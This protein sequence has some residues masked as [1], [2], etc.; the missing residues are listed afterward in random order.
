[1]KIPLLFI[2]V[3]ILGGC[4]FP[5]VPL[6]T[7]EPIK[8]EPLEVK[9]R[10]DVYQHGE[11][12]EGDELKQAVEAE[13]IVQRQRNRMAEIQELKNNRIV[14]ESHRGLLEIRTLPGGDW[15]AHVKE[16]VEAENYD[17]TFLMRAEAR[18]KDILLPKVQ[19]EQ[20]LRRLELSFEGEWIEILDPNKEGGFQWYQK[21]K[22]GVAL[23]DGAIG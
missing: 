10:L 20:W 18:R 16:T 17:R 4:S 8:I 12:K 1:M 22:K 15:G 14:G 2:I 21:P 9:I 7:P 11:A 6:T 19:K 3:A 5:E 23:P 13:E